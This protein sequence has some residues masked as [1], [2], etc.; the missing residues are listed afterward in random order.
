MPW[1][2]LLVIAG[3]SGSGKSTVGAELAT[4][5][6]LEFLDADD[7]HPA[8][9]V[10]K[11]ASGTALSDNDR[12]PWLAAVGAALDAASATGLVVACS[13]LKRSYRAAILAVAPA[14]RFV[15]LDGSRE[16]LV[17]RVGARRDHFM[18]AALLDSQL[19]TLEPLALG[20]RGF[21]VG[22]DGTPGEIVEIIAGRL[23]D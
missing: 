16:L 22:I 2:P 4:A 6:G 7:L 19:A 17:E 8:S 9:N 15:L 20:E 11:M 5:L 12:W 1:P 14:T 13:A 10:R 21:T 3:V 18:P 23:G